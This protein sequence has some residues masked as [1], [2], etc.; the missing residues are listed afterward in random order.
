MHFCTFVSHFNMSKSVS[1]VVFSA[2]QLHYDFLP[3]YRAGFTLNYFSFFCPWR[4]QS[5]V[6]CSFF[7]LLVPFGP[8]LYKFCLSNLC[9]LVYFLYKLVSF[10]STLYLFY[11]KPLSKKTQPLSLSPFYLCRAQFLNVNILRLQ[12]KPIDYYL[13]LALSIAKQCDYLT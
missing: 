1:A 10:L 13:L 9:F 11:P 7:A 8:S 12:P 6:A 4:T 3:F 2:P 5:P